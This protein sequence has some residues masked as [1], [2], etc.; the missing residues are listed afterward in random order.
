MNNFKSNDD[1][2]N[3]NYLLKLGKKYKINAEAGHLNE[4]G[5]SVFSNGD[6]TYSTDVNTDYQRLEYE[7]DKLTRSI[8]KVNNGFNES[9]NNQQLQK[10]TGNKGFVFIC[11]LIFVAFLIFASLD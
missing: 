8:N 4:K 11:I 9:G 2:Y 1:T 7:K 5:I 6:G 3:K 10:N